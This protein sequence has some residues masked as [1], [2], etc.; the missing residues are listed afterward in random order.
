M[1]L[2]SMSRPWAILSRPVRAGCGWIAS[3]C[4]SSS[5]RWPGSARSAPARNRR[6]PRRHRH[7]CG[8]SP[9]CRPSRSR[10]PALESRAACRTRRRALRPHGRLAVR[11]CGIRSRRHAPGRRSRRRRIRVRGPRSAGRRPW[12]PRR[13]SRSASRGAE[14]LADRIENGDMLAVGLA[15]QV[16]ALAVKDEILIHRVDDDACA[17][18]AGAVDERCRR[19]P[20][21]PSRWDYEGCSRRWRPRR[22]TACCSSSRPGRCRRGSA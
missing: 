8:P 16:A 4:R 5:G 20:A 15:R 3:A 11:C 13:S 2:S 18:H 12:R 22:P 9:A 1:L 19:R 10:T 17:V 21:G 7:R 14:I 6:R